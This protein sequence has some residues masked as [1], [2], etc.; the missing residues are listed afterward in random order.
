LTAVE[1]KVFHY[2]ARLQGKGRN[3]YG[4]VGADFVLYAKFADLG[5][6]TFFD[7]LEDAG[8]LGAGAPGTREA[9]TRRLR[10]S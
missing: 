5:E 9:V 3:L 8:V 6:L 7:R 4:P 10:D 1:T 2:G